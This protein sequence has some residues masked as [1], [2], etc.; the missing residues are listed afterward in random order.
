MSH[1]IYAK[2]AV[3]IAPAGSRWH[4]TNVWSKP[5]RTTVHIIR[6]ERGAIRSLYGSEVDTYELEGDPA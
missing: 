2:G 5:G 3:L 4:V 6:S 1:S